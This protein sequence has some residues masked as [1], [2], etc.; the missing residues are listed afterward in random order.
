MET[1]MVLNGFKGGEG[2]VAKGVVGLEITVGSKTP[3]IDFFI[4]E[5]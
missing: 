3:A 4:A 1:N 5:V 2:V